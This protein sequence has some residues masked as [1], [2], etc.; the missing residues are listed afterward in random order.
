MKIYIEA[1]KKREVLK[2]ELR[3]LHVKA[4]TIREENMKEFEAILTDVQKSELV[5][6]K[7]EGRK[8]FAKRHKKGYRKPIEK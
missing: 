4:K 8:N 2:K 3:D 6:I 7:K 5:K 1:A